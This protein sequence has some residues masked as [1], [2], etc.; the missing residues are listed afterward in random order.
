MPEVVGVDVAAEGAGMLETGGAAVG[1]GFCMA[2]VMVKVT[3]KTV[4]MPNPRAIFRVRFISNLFL[5]D[6]AS[7]SRARTEVIIL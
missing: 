1:D 5:V 7:F 2:T 4:S 6:G 3:T